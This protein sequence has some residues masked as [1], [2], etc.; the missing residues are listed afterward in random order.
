MT[1]AFARSLPT[2]RRPLLAVVV[3]LGCLVAPSATLAEEDV[4]DI[5]RRAWDQQRGLSSYAEITMTIHRADWERSMSMRAW[6]AGLEEA[7]VRV[8]APKKDAGNGTLTKDDAMWSF[9]PKINRVIK[10]PSSMMSQSWMGSDFSNKD[11]SRSADIID[12]YEHVLLDPEEHDG[13]KVWVIESTPHE[14]SAVVWGKEVL[15][16]RE[17]FVLISQEFF[18]QD[19]EPVKRMEALEV[20]E[21]GGRPMAIRLRMAETGQDEEWTEIHYQTL[22]F[23]IELSK[24][25]FTL[26]NLRN[27]R[28]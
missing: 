2:V 1:H 13:K 12:D 17:D 6:T 16:V 9:A 21:L 7:L 27:P 14:D 15:R 20:G 10:I 18:D 28:E 8:T 3:L 11:I 24:N 5:V 25:M 23:D 19:G 4:R 22:E 26:S